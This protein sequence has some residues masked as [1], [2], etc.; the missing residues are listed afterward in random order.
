MSKTTKRKVILVLTAIMLILS[1][2]N[3]T[4]FASISSSTTGSITV[5]NLEPGVTAYLYQLTTV[6]VNDSS[7]QPQDPTYYW[8]EAVQDWIATN[9]PDFID[10]DDGSVTTAF[11][12]EDYTDYSTDVTTFYSEL[13]AAIKGGEISLSYT[14]SQTTSGTASYPV[15]EDSCTESVTF[16]SLAMGTYLVLVENGY[17]VYTPVVANLTPEYDEDSSAWVLNDVTAE[18]KST[19][20]SITKYFTDTSLT[21]DNYSSVDTISYTIVADIPTYEADS[22]STTY[23]ISDS[24]DGGLTVDTTSITVYGVSGTSETVLVEDTAYTLSYNGIVYTFSFDYDEISSYEQIKITYNASLTAGG[25]DALTTGKAGNGNTATLTYSNNPYVASSTQSQDTDEVQV[26][27][28]GIEITKVDSSDTSVTLEG[29]EFTLSDSNGNTLSFVKDEDSGI[30]YLS[31]SSDAS[32][33]LTS[34][35]DGTITIKGLDEGTYTLKETKAPDD[36]SINSTT[37]EITI[38]DADLDGLLDY[39]EADDNG[40]YEITFS[41]VAAFSLPLT[42]GMGTVL[43]TLFGVLIVVLGIALLSKSKKNKK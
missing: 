9:Y 33:T 25:V 37:V 4:A 3:L 22:L 34:N 13:I 43:F 36:Y 31:E 5:E 28:Y 18:C 38:E 24:V 14:S 7:S 27:T 35:S 1:S 15:D 32:T 42:G 41:D 10:T 20:P 19:T 8:V 29:A 16:S 11:N 30:Y 12:N 26:Y 17:R 39:D 21:A 40:I 6:N 2:L 23:E